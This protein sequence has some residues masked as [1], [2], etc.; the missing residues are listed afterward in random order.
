MASTYTDGLG[1]EL[2]GS[3]DKAGSWGDVTNNNLKALDQ[4]IRGY[5]SI[6]LTGASS[7]I[8]LEDGMTVSQDSGAAR[9]RSSVIKFTGAGATHTLTLQVG[10]SSSGMKTSF[11]AINA[12]DSTYDLRIDA[13]GSTDLTIPN[14][15]AAH[16]HI[17][18]TS[19]LNSY[20]NF[21]TESL[22]VGS[23]SANG[24]IKSNG[25][26]DLILKTGDT[27]TGSIVIENG[28][29][30]DIQINPNGSGPVQIYSSFLDFPQSTAV[31]L[32]NS[33]NEAL[34][35]KEGSNSYLEFDTS[36]K[37]V[38][39]GEETSDCETLQIDTATVDLSVQA[40]SLSLNTSSTTALDFKKSSTSLLSLDTTNTKVVIPTV[41]INGGAIDGATIGGASA[42]A[43]TFTS[44]NSADMALTGG[45]AYLNFSTLNSATGFG[46]R[47][48]SGA[49][50]IKNK[51]GSNDDW[52]QPYHA[53]MKSGSGAYLE[54]TN[55]SFGNAANT[56]YTFD[57][58]S[59]GISSGDIPRIIEIWAKRTGSSDDAGYA[60]NTW[61]RMDGG[62]NYG[63]ANGGYPVSSTH[64]TVRIHTGS[65]SGAAVSSL[66][67]GNRT[68]LSSTG[69]DLY[70]R[71][72]A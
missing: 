70:C 44:V 52:G 14:G 45:D 26:Y 16:V 62:G 51:T 24:I 68:E 40:T 61:V 41:D 17:D 48:S 7:T 6:A 25:N 60:Q 39:I 19:V 4:A 49:F 64:D 3:G 47:E 20:T 28:S 71:V 37:K 59:L 34:D 43:G 13:N 27:T 42:G 58:S 69:W 56:S 21:L 22:M 15:Y 23:G 12:L 32:T 63:N 11:I 67:N 65:A 50:Q 46:L 9:I 54:V 57:I 72:W 53:G 5:S 36:G 30:G 35:F 8:N 2:I 55:T 31:R 18:G 38:V 66:T 33:L 29:S 1:I 10:G